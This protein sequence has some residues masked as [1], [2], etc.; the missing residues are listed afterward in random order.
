MKFFYSR[1]MTNFLL[2]G[3]LLTL[4]AHL[5]IKTEPSAS[6]ETLFL[7]NCVTMGID[8][9]PKQYVHVVTHSPAESR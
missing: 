9:A 2:A 4:A 7:D 3:I 8:Q 5:F 6:A 1:R